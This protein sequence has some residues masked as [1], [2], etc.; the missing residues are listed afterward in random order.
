MDSACHQRM[1]VRRI[2]VPVDFSDV[3]M[4]AYKTARSLAE[5]F[6]APIEVLHVVE[7]TEGLSNATAFVGAPLDGGEMALEAARARVDEF[8]RAAG[9]DPAELT[10]QV[11]PGSSAAAG[12]V[13]EA[14]EGDLIVMGSHGRSGLKRLVLGS[15]AEEVLR[16][17]TC[18]V[19]VA[20]TVL[21]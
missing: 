12:I 1:Q 21:T 6:D 17:T 2:L 13:D 3:S 19:L 14:K 10:A 16:T 18:P 11:V 15:T 20:P 5:N 8:V 4:N 7:H 9:T